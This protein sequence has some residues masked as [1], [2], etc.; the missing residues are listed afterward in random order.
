M[1]SNPRVTREIIDRAHPSDSTPFAPV[2]E[3]FSLLV[4]ALAS[5]TCVETA[6]A[7]DSERMLS[8]HPSPRL[9]HSPCSIVDP[10][11]RNRA[12]VSNDVNVVGKT[13]PHSVQTES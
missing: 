4:S 12:S 5:P 8:V 2:G 1:A 3:T 6:R 11:Q 13:F 7:A 9:S 10:S